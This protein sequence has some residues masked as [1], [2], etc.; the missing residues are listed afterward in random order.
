MPLGTGPHWSTAEARSNNT[1]DRRV[2][3]RLPVRR[4]CRFQPG[5]GLANWA[6][7]YLTSAKS[8]VFPP[9]VADPAAPNAAYGAP[10]C[11]KTSGGGPG[12][13]DYDSDGYDDYGY[14]VCN[15][16]RLLVRISVVAP[17][18]TALGTNGAEQNIALFYDHESVPSN[19]EIATLRK[20]QF[21]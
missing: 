5:Y 9:P 13:I 12:I 4:N 6:K 15:G 7:N 21:K 11:Q 14:L 8:Q 16:H 17:D 20:T 1:I 10:P 3:K 2:G 18:A 19:I